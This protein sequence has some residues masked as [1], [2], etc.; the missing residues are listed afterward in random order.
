MVFLAVNLN[1]QLKS[2]PFPSRIP[3]WRWGPA[4][5]DAGG[6]FRAQGGVFMLP[7]RQQ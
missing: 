4:E 7:V 2:P 1:T 3:S 5:L 6:V